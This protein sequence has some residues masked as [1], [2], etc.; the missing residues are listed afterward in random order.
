MNAMQTYT[1]NRSQESSLVTAGRSELEGC[2]VARS[3]DG[4]QV[5]A[6]AKSI[7]VLRVKLSE[8]GLRFADVVIEGPM[9]PFASDSCVR[10]DQE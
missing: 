8:T 7:D 10:V 1:Q 2:F 9:E 4:L 5:L 3:L 6:F